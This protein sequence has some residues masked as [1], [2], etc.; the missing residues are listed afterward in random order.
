VVLVRTD[1]SKAFIASIIRVTEIG[2]LGATL[3]VTSNLSTLG[4]DTV[5]AAFFGCYLLLTMLQFADSCYSDNEGDTFLRIVGSYES[6]TALTS[7]RTES[8]TTVMSAFMLHLIVR[9]LV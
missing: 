5:F 7:Q 4:R 6:H 8:F 1:V 9:L 2:E 3:A